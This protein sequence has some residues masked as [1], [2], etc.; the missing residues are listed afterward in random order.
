VFSTETACSIIKH[1]SNTP[2]VDPDT[3]YDK[4]RSGI[5]EINSA[6]FEREELF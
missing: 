6:N 1:I 5:D 3:K 4:P 2:K